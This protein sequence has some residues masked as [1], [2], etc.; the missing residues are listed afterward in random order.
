MN[1]V[2]ETLMFKFLH[3]NYPISRVK[4]NFKFKRAIILEKG[5]FVLSDK[6]ARVFLKI[7]LINILKKVFSCDEK[8]C[9]SITS[10]FLKLT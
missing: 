9:A 3:C 2:N 5:V 7:E 4:V 8:T 6:A 10:Q 1:T